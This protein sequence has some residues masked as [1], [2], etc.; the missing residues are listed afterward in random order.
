MAQSVQVMAQFGVGMSQVGGY[1]TGR[2]D[3]PG[4]GMVQNV[5][6]MA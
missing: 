5:A 2:E 4:T 3:V 1:W 6:D